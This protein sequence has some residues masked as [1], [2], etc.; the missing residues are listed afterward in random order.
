MRSVEF[1]DLV[2]AH[3][4]IR[5]L[6]LFEAFKT[7]KPD[8]VISPDFA[9]QIIARL[10]NWYVKIDKIDWGLESEDSDSNL[11]W[12]EQYFLLAPSVDAQIMIEVGDYHYYVRV[13]V[14]GDC[15][16]DTFRHWEDIP[17]FIDHSLNMI[18]SSIYAKYVVDADREFPFGVLT[19]EDALCT[20]QLDDFWH[21]SS[22]D[23][24]QSVCAWGYVVIN[25][26][27]ENAPI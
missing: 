5:A 14:N 2:A 22:K 18:N 27:D 19:Y 24:E 9:M 13:E 15:Q 6:E 10:A 11:Q 8:V 1:D 21:S 26:G 3:G 25:K 16:D 4:Q 12:C 7:T 17:E 20:E 23:R